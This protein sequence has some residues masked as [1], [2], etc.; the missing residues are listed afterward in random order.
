MTITT[1]AGDRGS[2]AV[3]D[4]R[5]LKSDPLIGALGDLDECSSLLVYMVAHLKL[6]RQ[7]WE[8]VVRNLAAIGS[9]L[10]R[11]ADSVSLEEPIREMEAYIK[12]KQFRTDRFIYPFEDEKNA[13]LHYVRTVARRTERSMV[14][15]SQHQAL[16]PAVLIY[17]NRLSDFIFA[18]G[19]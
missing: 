11:Y 14:L 1:K 8:A 7:E 13:L 17:F 2:T 4:E 19:L 6:E 3:K 18:H 10:A 16:D 15:L 5:L 12:Q 9:Y